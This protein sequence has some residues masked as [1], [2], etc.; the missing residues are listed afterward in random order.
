LAAAFAAALDAGRTD[1]PRLEALGAALV[2]RLEAVRGPG[3]SVA[4]L[5]GAPRSHRIDALVLKGVPAMTQ[6]MA[7]DLAGFAVSAGSACS[8]GKVEASPVLRAMGLPPEVAG[9]TIR[10]SLGWTTTEDEVERFAAAYL[11]VAE[12]LSAPGPS[13]L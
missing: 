1:A 4:A 13:M 6:L 10:V 9:C 8:S 5:V 3:V 11:A 7:L 12:R 2:R